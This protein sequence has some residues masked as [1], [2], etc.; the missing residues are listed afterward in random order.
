MVSE[1]DILIWE[2][3]DSQS[4]GFWGTNNFPKQTILLQNS[5]FVGLKLKYKIMQN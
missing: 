4:I 1:M 3:L 5:S 2:N